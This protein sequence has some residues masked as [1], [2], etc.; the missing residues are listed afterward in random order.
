MARRWPA[1]GVGLAEAPPLLQAAIA[2]ARSRIAA[3]GGAQGNHE[4][5]LPRSGTGLVGTAG[6]CRIAKAPSG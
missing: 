2:K 4:C 1:K 6:T 5:G 3:S